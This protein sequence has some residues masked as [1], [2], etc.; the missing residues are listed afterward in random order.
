VLFWNGDD[1]RFEVYLP[2]RGEFRDLLG[3]LL[4]KTSMLDIGISDDTK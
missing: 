2:Q 4:A 3:N 1:L